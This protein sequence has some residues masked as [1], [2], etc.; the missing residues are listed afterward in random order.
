MGR[1]GEGASHE[2]S[3]LSVQ[4]M[5]RRK[6]NVFLDLQVLYKARLFPI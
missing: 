4:K 5:N 3:F 2:G 1:A 6:R